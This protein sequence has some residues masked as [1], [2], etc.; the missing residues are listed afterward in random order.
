MSTHIPFSDTEHGEWY[1]LWVDGP[2]GQHWMRG[3]RQT[4]WPDGF[5][6][7]DDGGDPAVVDHHEDGLISL[8]SKWKILHIQA[9]P[10]PPPP[11]VAFVPTAHWIVELQRGCWLA[12]WG[13]CC[14]RTMKRQSAQQFKTRAAA[15]GAIT[16]FRKYRTLTA[17]KIIAVEAT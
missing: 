17:P 12:P 14:G 8:R 6:L 10:E 3:R 16:R 1:F 9:N 7:P 2:D 15:K 5:M 13:D 11:P 4:R